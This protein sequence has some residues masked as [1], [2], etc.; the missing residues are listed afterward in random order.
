VNNHHWAIILAAGEGSRIRHFM[1]DAEGL[2]IP[3]QFWSFDGRK[4]MLDWSIDRAETVVPRARIVVVVADEHRKWWEKGLQRLLPEN[5]VVQ[6]ENRGTAIGVLLPLLTVLRRDPDATT[7]VLPSDHFVEHEPVLRSAVED[8]LGVVDA[9]TPT[10]AVLLGM[11]PGADDQEYGWILPDTRRAGPALARVKA[12]VEKPNNSEAAL[13]RRKGALINSLIL[14]T[15]ARRLLELCETNLPAA[16]RSLAQVV[17][18][19]RTHAGFHALAQLYDRL[20]FLDF[21]REILATHA[22]ELFVIR[23]PDCGWSDLG[24]PARFM[25]FRRRQSRTAVSRISQPAFR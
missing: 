23:V 3:K 22:G 16:T 14:T 19:P 9:D 20:P 1:T 24:T 5:V 6:P 17:A 10:A 2:T 4:T 12:F 21:S 11:V 7:V 15:K 13:L 18:Q 8:A 25:M